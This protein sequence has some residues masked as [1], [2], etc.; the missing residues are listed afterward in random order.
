MEGERLQK[1]KSGKREGQREGN[2]K[3][4]SSDEELYMLSSQWGK[5]NT[6]DRLP[7]RA[8]TY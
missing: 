6:F 8:N 3:S 7:K 1:R 5:G 4:A 2:R